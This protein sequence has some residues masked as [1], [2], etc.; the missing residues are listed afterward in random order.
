MRILFIFAFLISLNSLT[1][2]EVVSAETI[3]HA[4]SVWLQNSTY[5]NSPEQPGNF[6]IDNEHIYPLFKEN[7]SKIIGWIVP[8]R[9]G[10]FIVFTA[11]YRLNPVF[12][13]SKKG[14]VTEQ[15]LSD[16]FLQEFS[17]SEIQFRLQ[18]LQNKLLNRNKT[19]INRKSWD[20]LIN[21]TYKSSANAKIKN[22]TG[23]Y[24]KSNWG[25]GTA[26]GETTFNL[27]TPNNW[28]V[29]C[30]ATAMAQILNY[31]NWPSRGTGAH[32]YD[33]GS[34]GWLE[35]D[36]KNT[37]YDWSL[38]KDIYQGAF[39]RQVEKEEVSKLSYHCG[40]S[41][42]MDYSATGSTSETADV[43][44]ALSDYFRFSGNY[45]SV[46]NGLYDTLKSNILLGR[47]AQIS[48]YADN[49]AGHSA[50]VDGYWQDN[51]KY[52]LVP[53]WNGDWTGWY[54]I[55]GS[56]NMAGYTIVE[57][58]VIDIVPTPM[59]NT[60]EMT[61]DSSYFV[62]WS[63]SSNF[64]STAYELQEANS[65]VGPWSTLT[66][67]S[68]DTAFYIVKNTLGKYYYRVRAR[69]NDRWW[70]WSQA[71]E[72]KMASNRVL[73][74]YVDLSSRPLAEDEEVGLRGS[75]PPLAGGHNSP[76]MTGENEDGI[77]TTQISF[78]YD[79]VGQELEYRYAIISTSGL[80]ME[81]QS[82]FYILN[83]NPVSSTDTSVFNQFT[84]IEDDLA[85]NLPLTSTL[86]DNYPNPFNNSTR[87]RFFL[88]TSANV[89]IA[90][91]N[92]AGQRVARIR[93]GFY[94]AGK[95]Q[96]IIDMGKYSVSSGTYFLTFHSDQSKQVIKMT[97][98]K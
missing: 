39:T 38:I 68:I 84:D 56:W 32:G 48:I 55:E 61:S 3:E 5:F 50:V 43:A 21:D 2:S 52:H 16:S 60:V 1:A 64:T 71:K 47:I 24:L 70:D 88:A 78:D 74:F 22:M 62:T 79:Y 65:P 8:L 46:K 27:L 6:T 98:S 34:S 87:V 59:I 31:Y 54:D 17:V 85:D 80:E 72:V 93:N 23:P 37:I 63:V 95:H 94:A 81:N 42:N 86:Y 15:R 28:A 30:V 66:S 4:A 51:G 77:Y 82:R 36:Y 19:D 9:P 44:N 57:G 75:I 58:G 45:V 7:K 91:F 33:A 11:D 13:F 26:N 90:L 92:I 53:G 73:N 40:V 49:G 14:I 29:G 18:A 97:Y 96:L 89:K 10:G 35:V 12:A 76:P 20:H 25:Q 41:V 83:E 69:A 67:Q